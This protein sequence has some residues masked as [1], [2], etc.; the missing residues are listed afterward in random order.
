MQHA[1]EVSRE[2]QLVPWHLW[3]PGPNGSVAVVLIE[4]NERRGGVAISAALVQRCNL[5]SAHE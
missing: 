1:A 3:F 2:V 5:S 4:Q